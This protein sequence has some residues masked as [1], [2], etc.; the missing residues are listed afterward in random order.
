MAK[1]AKPRM[2]SNNSVKV[3]GTSSETTSSVMAK[4][5]TASLSASMRVTSP[6]PRILKLLSRPKPFS[7]SFL[8]INFIPRQFVGAE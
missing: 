6:V 8:R 4:P 3:C 2:I 7:I 1:A 5:K